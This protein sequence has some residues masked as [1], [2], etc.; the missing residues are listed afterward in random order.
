MQ[1]EWYE[2]R[3]KGRLPAGWAAWFEGMAVREAEE[4]ESLLVGPV[5]DQA[6]LHGV[7]AKVRDLNLTLVSVRRCGEKDGEQD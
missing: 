1:G 6:A 5:V 2:I 7:L 3:V 4:G